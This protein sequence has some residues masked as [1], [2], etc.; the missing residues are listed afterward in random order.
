M[1]VEL[2]QCAIMQHAAK[3]L[4][5]RGVSLRVRNLGTRGRS[6]IG[7]TPRPLYAG[8]DPRYSLD[9]FGPPLFQWRQGGEKKNLLLRP[10]IELRFPDRPARSLVSILTELSKIANSHSFVLRSYRKTFITATQDKIG[11]TTHHHRTHG[12]MGAYPKNW[13]Y[14]QKHSIY[15]S[16][17]RVI[18]RWP[19][20]VE[21]CCVHTPVMRMRF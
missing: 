18:W 11:G 20:L 8:E 21:T 1:K 5:I 2:S 7:L 19:T 10:G 16:D 15:I 17:F 6:E 3:R 13:T 9:R 12:R 4:R 14:G